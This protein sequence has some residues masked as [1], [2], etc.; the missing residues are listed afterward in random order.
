[1]KSHCYK[2][3]FGEGRSRRMFVTIATSEH[4]AINKIIAIFTN[5]DRVYGR[6]EEPLDTEHVKVATDPNDILVVYG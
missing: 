6:C 1:M 4:E 3:T 5:R 2:V